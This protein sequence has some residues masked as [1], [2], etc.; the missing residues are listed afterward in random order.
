MPYSEAP[1]H[2]PRAAQTP[3][4]LVDQHH[5]R[6]NLALLV[7]YLHPLLLRDDDDDGG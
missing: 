5:V 3:G 6:R 7:G 4:E 2:R 1:Q